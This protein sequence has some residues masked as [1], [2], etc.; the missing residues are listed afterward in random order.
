MNYKVS[1]QELAIIQQRILFK[2]HPTTLEKAKKRVE[3]LKNQS[4]QK[5]KKQSLNSITP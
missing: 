2:Q 3:T 5:N 1:F 4:S